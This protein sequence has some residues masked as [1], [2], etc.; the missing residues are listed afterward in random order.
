M[1]AGSQHSRSLYSCFAASADTAVAICAG[2]GSARGLP[3]ALPNRVWSRSE[4]ALLF[5]RMARGDIR[6]QHRASVFRRPAEVVETAAVRIRRADAGR[7]MFRNMEDSR[8]AQNRC[9][10]EARFADIVGTD[11]LSLKGRVSL[12]CFPTT[13]QTLL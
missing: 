3:R 1:G 10:K 12:L 4:P 11:R 5:R 6:A 8:P 9:G 7:G 2:F 13:Q